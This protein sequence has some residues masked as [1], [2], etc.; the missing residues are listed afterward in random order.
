MS[1]GQRP[2]ACVRGC[3]CGCGCG[4][5]YGCACAC[6]QALTAWMLNCLQLAHM[7][8]HLMQSQ[9]TNEDLK[10]GLRAGEVRG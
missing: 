10:N 6:V 9:S 2:L 3:N 7:K 8:M 4:C 1:S 5:G